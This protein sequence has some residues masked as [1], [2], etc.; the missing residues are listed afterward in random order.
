M[1]EKEMSAKDIE[2]YFIQLG[3]ELEHQGVRRPIRILMI[4][5]GYMILIAKM[6]RTTKDVDF[7]WLEDDE[8]VL[9]KDIYAFRDGVDA[10]AEKTGLEVDWI[11]YVT[12]ILMQDQVVL[13]P[14]GR[15]WRKFG[16]L[17]VHVPSR[18]F[19]LALKMVA[20]RQKDLLDCEVLLKKMNVRTREQAQILMD[21]Y[22][23]PEVQADKVEEIER[24]FSKFFG[25]KQ[26]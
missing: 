16:P 1:A 23:F 8:E 25:G 5:G 4:G 6:K 2:T 11:N 7:F 15:L 17:H 24:S 12:H 21:Q 3:E 13:I 19:M 18:E 26:S 20:S 22:I 14:K 10:V 9:Q